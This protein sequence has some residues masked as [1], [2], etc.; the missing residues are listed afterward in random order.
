MDPGARARALGRR[1]QCPRVDAAAF[2]WSDV[3]DG[4]QAAPWIWWAVALV[5]LLA[6]LLAGMKALGLFPD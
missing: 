4:T 1:A 2:S 3:L 5:V 6:L